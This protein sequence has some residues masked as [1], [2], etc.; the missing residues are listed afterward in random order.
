VRH[1]RGLPA[2]SGSSGSDFDGGV[3]YLLKDRVSDLSS[4]G[5]DLRKVALIPSSSHGSSPAGVNATRS[6]DSPIGKGP[7]SPSWRKG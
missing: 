2:G 6:T 4:F 5:A 7:S 1:G 3:G